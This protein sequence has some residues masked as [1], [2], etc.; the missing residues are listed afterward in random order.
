M[1]KKLIRKI[2]Y[3]ERCSSNTYVEYLKKKGIN[4]GENCRIFDPM[5]NIIDTQN[6]YMLS[7]GDNV[8]ITSGVI[9]LTHD[10]S[11]S[12]IAN[13]YGDVLGGVGNVSIGNNVFIGMNSIILKDTIIEDNVI[14]GAGSVVSGKLESNFVYAGNPAR[15]IKSLEEFYKKRKDCQ[16]K[17]IESIFENVSKRMHRKPTK[18]ELQEYFSYY[19]NFENLDNNDYNRIERIGKKNSILEFLKNKNIPQY[20]NYDELIKKFKLEE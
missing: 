6:P 13:Y 3:K 10:Y 12:V 1:I 20:E 17:E 9:I 11:W 16:T 7:I 5:T 8:S 2:I 4:I 18:E 15:K 14:I 19:T